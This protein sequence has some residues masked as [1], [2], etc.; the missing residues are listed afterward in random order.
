MFVIT[1]TLTLTLNQALMGRDLCACAVTGSGKTAAF[2]LPTL[3]RLL[4]RDKVEA[5]TR[6]LIL[7]PTRELAAQVTPFHQ[8]RLFFPFLT[9]FF[10]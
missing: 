1:V 2:L 10:G 7:S 4:Y 8:N 9:F 3:E 6:V 5:A